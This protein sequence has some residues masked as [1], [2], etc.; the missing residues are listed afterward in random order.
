MFIILLDVSSL[1]QCLHP[2]A[3]ATIET[4]IPHIHPYIQHELPNKLPLSMV[5]DESQII[6]KYL[7]KIVQPFHDNL[8]S[9]YYSIPFHVLLHLDNLK[10]QVMMKKW[11]IHFVFR[12]IPCFIF[13]KPP[14]PIFWAT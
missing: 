7:M 12:V 8:Q 1:Q 11:A 10:P 2:L 6:V 14:I 3:T 4:Q 13:K 9:Y 5:I